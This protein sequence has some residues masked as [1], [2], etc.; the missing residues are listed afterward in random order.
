MK[1]KLV[2]SPKILHALYSI[3]IPGLFL[4][5]CAKICNLLLGGWIDLGINSVT[6]LFI[7]LIA[8]E[9][10]LVG[11]ILY[12]ERVEE[13]H[14]IREITL[15]LLALIGI[16]LLVTPGSWP[17]KL[18]SIQTIP[19]ITLC[20][21]VV[22]QWFLSFSIHLDLRQREILL[23]TCAQLTGNAL[24][25]EIRKHIVL[26]DNVQAKIISTKRKLVTFQ[27]LCLLG[28]GLLYITHKTF[29]PLFIGLNIFHMLFG[30]ISFILLNRML[31]EHN[32]FAEGI[33]PNALSK[34]KHSYYILFAFAIILVLAFLAAKDSSLFS[35]ALFT[36]VLTWF[37][38]LFR[39]ERV[40]PIPPQMTDNSFL[41]LNH[42]LDKAVPSFKHNFF[43]QVLAWIFT[44]FTYMLLALLA[45]SFLYYLFSPFFSRYFRWAI[46]W[47]V[48]WQALRAALC[49]IL[50]S[51]RHVW[52]DFFQWFNSKSQYTTEKGT[53]ERVREVLEL[54]AARKLKI[55]KRL[56]IRNFIKAF[57]KLAFWGA[58][59]KQVSYQKH[60]GPLEYG[61]QLMAVAPQQAEIIHT[62]L[63]IFEEGLFSHHLVEKEKVKL[64]YKLVREIITS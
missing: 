35:L 4:L 61:R 16:R 12:N 56:Q 13:Y 60:L 50:Y 27:V 64:Y 9:E 32:L 14:R 28:L 36:P 8:L 46:N 30:W 38:G 18:A 47:K 11:Y 63:E 7:F 53:K 6:A 55:S 39:G 59:K 19:F 37:L 26:F 48:P 33:R 49:R 22:S 40:T 25:L 34:R 43:L 20:V 42:Y 2:L 17:A 54:K 57:L 41:N 23:T 45:I 3:F 24:S 52:Q 10:A 1:Q 31:D 5:I 62:A 51:L 21:L 29:S 58:S 44:G 15:I